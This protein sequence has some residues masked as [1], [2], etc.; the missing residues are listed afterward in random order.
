M[1][2]FPESTWSLLKGQPILPRK[3]GDIK[4][5]QE[6][7]KPIVPIILDYND[8]NCFVKYCD[9]IY[10]SK[11]DDV[12]EIDKYF[13]NLKESDK[14]QNYNFVLSKMNLPKRVF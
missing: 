1:L 7:G 3:W 2:L 14:E 5:A 10:V 9:P 4:L 12:K 11:D 13:L 8:N 6:T